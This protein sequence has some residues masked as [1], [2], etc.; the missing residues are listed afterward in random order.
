MFDLLMKNIDWIFS[1]Q[2]AYNKKSSYIHFI[3]MAQNQKCTSKNSSANLLTALKPGHIVY[4]IDFAQTSRN[5][6]VQQPSS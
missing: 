2:V 5:P 3:Y 1:I 6:S 4:E